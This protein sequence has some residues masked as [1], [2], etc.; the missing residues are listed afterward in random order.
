MAQNET[1]PY[2]D[3]CRKAGCMPHGRLVVPFAARASYEF[4]SRQSAAA[5]LAYFQTMEWVSRREADV[6]YDLIQ[7][8]LLPKSEEEADRILREIARKRGTHKV[9]MREFCCRNKF[10]AVAYDTEN[11]QQIYAPN[12]V[13]CALKFVM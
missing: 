4:L 1:R 2:W 3:I 13:S 6:L 11:S 5:V 8:L 7:T 9:Y 10:A 12:Q